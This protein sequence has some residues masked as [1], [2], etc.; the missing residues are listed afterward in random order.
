MEC[1]SGILSPFHVLIQD[2]QGRHVWAIRQRHPSGYLL[3]FLGLRTMFP[4]LFEVEGTSRRYWIRRPAGLFRYRYA[5]ESPEHHVL[6]RINC[7][8]GGWKIEDQWRQ[9]VGEVKFFIRW[10]SGGIRRILTAGNG[11]TMAEIELAPNYFTTKWRG[12]LFLRTP[13][14]EWDVLTAAVAAIS[15]AHLQE[16]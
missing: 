1:I 16:R 6:W 12:R 11:D 7:G 15:I 10:T 4:L 14:E 3:R 8:L 2:E 9:I 13:T 5:V